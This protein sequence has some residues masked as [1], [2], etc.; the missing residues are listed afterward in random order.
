MSHVDYL[1]EAGAHWILAVKGNQPN[2]HR[3]LAGVPWQAVPDVFQPAAARSAPSR[4]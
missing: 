2:L 3:Q 1:A 4:P